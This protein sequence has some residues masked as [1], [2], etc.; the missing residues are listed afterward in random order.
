MAWLTAFTALRS[1]PGVYVD[2]GVSPRELR[3]EEF[4]LEPDTLMEVVS[5]GNQSMLNDG[6]FVPDVCKN[7]LGIWRGLER[8]GQ[9]EALCYAGFPSGEFAATYSM[10]FHRQ[11][12][13]V[14]M[15]FV[16]P[17]FTVSKWRWSAVDSDGTGFPTSHQ[18]RFGVRLWPQ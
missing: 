5:T 4:D 6:W 7:P 3:E 8:A 1:F 18:T 14:F 9:E 12:H 2:E 17:D 15:V 10:S 13:R 11:E 16:T